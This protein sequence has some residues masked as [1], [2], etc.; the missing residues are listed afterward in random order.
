VKPAM[1][2]SADEEE[3]D[4]KFNPSNPIHSFKKMVGF[5]K[6]DLVG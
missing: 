1:K 5:N 6:R 4:V 2:F 3:D